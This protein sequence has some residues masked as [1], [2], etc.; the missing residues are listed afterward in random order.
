MPAGTIRFEISGSPSRSPVTA[1]IV[2]Q[3]V[4]SVPALVM[5]ILEPLTTQLP[6]RSSAR[7]RVAPG[8][9]AGFGLGEAE[10]GEPPARRE[11]REPAATLL[12]GAEEEDRHRAERGVGGDR[13]RHRRVDAGKLLDNERVRQG[14]ETRASV[15]LGDRDA[16]DAELREAGDDVVREAVLPVE[17]R[18]DGR[19]PRL[20]ELSH[21]ATEELAVL[22]EIE[23]HAVRV[24]SASRAASSASSRTP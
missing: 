21:G 7:E 3:A 20:G 15:V 16:H 8:V 2:T 10:G 19:D 17:L 22:A 4:M 1:V 14:V 9:R 12:V 6:S 13:D 23:V 24:L 11:V 5:N 18:G